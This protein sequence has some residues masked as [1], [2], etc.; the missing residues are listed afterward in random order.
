LEIVMSYVFPVGPT[1]P[2]INNSDPGTNTSEPSATALQSSTSS[3][4]PAG[5]LQGR[6]P[7]LIFAGE[8]IMV[9]GRAYTVKDGD[10]LTSIAA[11]NGTTVKAL[12]NENSMNEALLG[13][14]AQGRYFS[15]A[16]PQ[17]PNGGATAT[18]PTSANGTAAP[19]N[20]PSTGNTNTSPARNNTPGAPLDESSSNGPTRS[21][22]NGTNNPP[23]QSPKLNDRDSAGI[24]G[25]PL[26]GPRLD[27]IPINN[28]PDGNSRMLTPWQVERA[29]VI[30]R[31]ISA[32]SNGPDGDFRQ[33]GI[34][35][36]NQDKAI[37]NWY[38]K[39]VLEIAAVPSPAGGGQ[40][41]A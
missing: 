33:G 12:I 24:E 11:A 35:L 18:A 32:G 2:P 37:L 10:T 13:P 25:G 28:L 8:K 5:A 26:I 19:N 39:E 23:L 7:D 34:H 29:Q 9:N 3:T 20:T 30:L 16:T 41:T 4:A 14:D 40:L 6:D 21:T 22:V 17:P 15:T 31:G 38:M 36:D 1:P 27:A